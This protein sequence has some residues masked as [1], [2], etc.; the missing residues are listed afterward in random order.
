MTDTSNLST[1][2][3]S[4]SA[5]DAEAL[6]QGGLQECHQERYEAGISKFKQASS[7]G[8]G[9]ATHYVGQM[10]KAGDGVKLDLHQAKV[11]YELSIK[12][13]NTDALL[14]LGHYYEYN[15][16]PSDNN[17]A[18]DLYQQAADQGNIEGLRRLAELYLYI[19]RLQDSEYFI[20]CRH[21][22]EEAIR[23]QPNNNLAYD[24]LANLYHCG[25]GVEK[26][27]IQAAQLI[28]EGYSRITDDHHQ[29]DREY[30]L[31][32]RSICNSRPRELF[33]SY[34]KLSNMVSQLQQE[35][36]KLRQDNTDLRMELYY[37][38][39]GPGFEQAKADFQSLVEKSSQK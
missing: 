23:R 5:V 35:N 18:I 3:S 32:F 7:M 39:D 22:L 14:S 19:G 11:Y 17:L 27:P 16:D 29:Q 25:Y 9:Q 8:H 15:S 31:S 13:G 24:D 20:K 12:Q 36:Q 4:T 37:C 6:F 30:I 34:V 33:Q 26:N 38:P 2:V 21:T 1:V 10:Y 28:T